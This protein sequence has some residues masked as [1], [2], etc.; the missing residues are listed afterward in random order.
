[1]AVAASPNKRRN[2]HRDYNRNRLYLKKICYICLQTQYHI[3]SGGVG[4]REVGGIDKLESENIPKESAQVLEY[5][6]HCH[7]YY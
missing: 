5:N 6:V 2:K 3:T 7:R 4:I 1:M